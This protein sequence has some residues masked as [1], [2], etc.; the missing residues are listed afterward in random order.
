MDS[1]IS[2]QDVANIITLVAPGYFALQAYSLINAKRDREFSQLLI[3]SIVYSLPIVALANFIWAKAFHLHTVP[4]LDAGYALLLIGLAIAG[5][6]IFSFLRV[7]WPAKQ[8]ARL[9]GIDS[10]SEDFI[11]TQL[12]RIDVH[13]PTASA[14]TVKLKSGGTFSGTIDRL[15]RYSHDGPKYY[16]FAN[17]A[18]LNEQTGKWNERGGGLLVN[19]EEIEYIETKK[20][21]D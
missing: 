17:L 16:C 13:D 5:G 6:G 15:S 12:L 10:P 9:W 21:R 4:S 14:V 7:H 18:W 2:L 20:L 1:P 3:E 8:L 11:K 19:R